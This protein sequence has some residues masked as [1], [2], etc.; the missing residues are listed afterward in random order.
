MSKAIP[1]VTYESPWFPAGGI[2]AVMAHLPVAVQ[3]AGK[4]PTVVITPFHRRSPK[5]AAL[6]LG[7]IDTIPMAYNG[8]TVSVEIRLHAGDCPWFFL[9]AEASGDL[10]PSFFDGKN[11]PYD[12]TGEIL[13]RDSLFFGAATVRALPAVADHLGVDPKEVEWNLIA[14]DWEAATALLAF[15][16][17]SVSKGRLHL[18]LHNSYDAFATLEDFSRVGIDPARCPGDTILH[19]ALT[20]I[21]RPAFTVSEQFA[22]DFTQDLLQ[23]EV[24]APQL[25]AL[26]N[27]NPVVGVDNGP[28]KSLAVSR[29]HLGDAAVGNFGLLKAWKAS[30][31]HTALSA[32]D[33][34]APTDREPVWGDKNKFRRDDSPWFVMAGR[35]DPRQKGYD[36]AAAAIE[37]Y[38]GEHQGEPGCS[39]FLF[40]P[41]PGDEGLPGLGFLQALAERYP[42][43]V[44]VFPFIWVAGFTAALQG[45]AYGLMPSLYE[46]FG[47]ANE[48]YFAG[49]CVGIAR[50]TGGNLEQIVP[51]RAASACSRAV[52]IRADR[53]HALSAHPTGI[54]FREKDEVASA[55]SDW[56]AINEA[57]YDKAGGA[58]SRVEERRHYGVFQEMANELRI[59]I[60]D[61]IRVYTQEP[62]LYYRMLAEGIPH[63]QRTFSWQR[64]GAEYVRKVGTLD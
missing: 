7:L 22:S 6:T 5:I 14:Q 49:G 15:A 4:W 30:S 42:G 25:Q 33:A 61:G 52:R 54:L 32:L 36:V 3:S 17:Q 51:L 23:R 19:R 11:H 63:I 24:M 29:A 2:A 35:D 39:Q 38:L 31:R 60:E 41:I 45:G 9:S 16:S 50:A 62:E 55:P 10:N 53:Y 48:L 1:F 44:I 37:D 40:F 8:T 43:D 27:R 26:L 34:H 13:L 47:M 20:I 18:T 64:A 57:R 58:P 56:K 28:F 46:P 12:V 59:A 21:E